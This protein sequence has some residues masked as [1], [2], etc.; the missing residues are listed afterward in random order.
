MEPFAGHSLREHLIAG[1][2]SLTTSWRVK[3]DYAWDSGVAAGR[4][5][6]GLKDGEILG[7]YCPGC[8]RTIVPPRAFCELC[9]RPIHQWVKLE[10][11]GRINTFSVS[12]VNWDAS[13]RETP[14]IPAVIEIDGASQGMGLLHVL[15]EVEG[16][17]KAVLSRVRI[18]MRVRAVWKPPEARTGSIT[19]IRYFKLVD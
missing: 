11:S 16:D 10:D 14:E 1:G 15:G 7:I 8:R 18:G 6:R 13:R 12:Y 2:E 17:L 4:F 3:A 19:D 9:F 5:L